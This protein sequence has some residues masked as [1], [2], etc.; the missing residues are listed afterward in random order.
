[1][2]DVYPIATPLRGTAYYDSDCGVC[3]LVLAGGSGFLGTLLARYFLIRGWEV[4]V[5]TCR[6]P[7]GRK[8]VPGARY[9]HWDGESP[10]PWQ[11]ELDGAEALINLAGQSV[12]CRYTRKNRERLTASRLRPTRLLGKILPTLE[13]PPRVWMNASTATL[14]RHTYGDPWREDGEIGAHPEAKDAF[15]IELATAWEEAFREA[16]EIPGVRK[17]L[18]RSAMV[19]GRNRDHNNVF[20]VLRR[21]TVTGLGGTMGQGRQYV[22]W[23][24]ETDFCRAVEWLIDQ[25]DVEGPVN[26]AAPNPLNNREMM[27]EFREALGVPFGLPAPGWLLEIGAFFLRTE[28][29][30]IIKSRRV[31]PRLLG[32]RGFTF[33]FPTMREAVRN[34]RRG[35][36]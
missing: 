7:T 26:L 8:S 14:Y 36:E 20:A 33:T 4:V 18:L 1:M 12:N 21:L 10:G 16:G 15:S 3:R 23:I 34:L 31:I 2:K 9:C 32:Q 28:T 19:L 29:E 35:G 13:R 5:L 24:H 6:P 11:K 22:S 27:R 25:A 30:L 17:I